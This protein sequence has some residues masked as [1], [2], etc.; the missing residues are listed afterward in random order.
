MDPAVALLIIKLI[1][2]V[3][4]G[5]EL[6][7]ELLARKDA[8]IAKIEAMIREGR[9]PTDEEMDELLNESSE[10]TAAVIAQRNF[11]RTHDP[12]LADQS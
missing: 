10:I 9:G 11:R 7:P 6:A 4:A 1:D 3:A 12:A 5:V 2:L 8:Y